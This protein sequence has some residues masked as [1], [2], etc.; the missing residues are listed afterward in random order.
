M[1]FSMQFKLVKRTNLNVYILARV[2]FILH[3][4]LNLMRR[5]G[6]GEE[7]NTS[8]FDHISIQ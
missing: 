4:L 6:G 2:S 1:R 5:R 7:L 8:I 3:A